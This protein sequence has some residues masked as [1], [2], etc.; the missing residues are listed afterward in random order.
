MLTPLVD[1]EY[2]L[3][4]SHG[5]LKQ[6]QFFVREPRSVGEVTAV[7]PSRKPSAGVCGVVY[8]AASLIN[9]FNL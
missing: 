6:F 8:H 2:L 9:C 7:R 4:F 1:D 5:I 3:E